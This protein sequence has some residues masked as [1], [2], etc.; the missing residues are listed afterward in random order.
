M[1]RIAL[2]PPEIGIISGTRAAFGF[3]LG[4]LLAPR[5]NHDQRRA[6]G[7][8]LLAVGAITTVPIVLQ[9]ARSQ[10]ESERADKGEGAGAAATQE[11]GRMSSSRATRQEY[12]S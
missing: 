5:L 7:W 9:I 11:P 1:N 10:R 12:V 2:S 4:L 3:G 6:I 8:T